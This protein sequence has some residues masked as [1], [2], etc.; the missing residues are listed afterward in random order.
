[1]I[2]LLSSDIWSEN[3]Q[4]EEY[5]N[6]RNSSNIGLSIRDV[7]FCPVEEDMIATGE[8]VNKSLIYK[9]KY[10]YLIFTT[11]IHVGSL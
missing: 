8:S 3:G 6:M 4:L 7:Q 1:M 5:M 11:L 2:I 9:V 10:A